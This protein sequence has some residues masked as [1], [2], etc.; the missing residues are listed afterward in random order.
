ML[1]VVPKDPS[2]V[3]THVLVLSTKTKKK[4]WAGRPYENPYLHKEYK[5]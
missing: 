4:H 5:H 2:T 1:T 3:S